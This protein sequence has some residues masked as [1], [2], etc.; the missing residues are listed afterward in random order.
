MFTSNKNFFA[1]YDILQ[2]LLPSGLQ[3]TRNRLIN[4]AFTE[5]LEKDSSISINKCFF[6][7]ISA[8]QIYKVRL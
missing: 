7:E 2:H 8:P 3:K 6:L 4:S 1:F 5:L